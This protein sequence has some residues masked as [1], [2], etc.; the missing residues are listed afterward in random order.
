[1]RRCP[2]CR[3]YLDDELLSVQDIPGGVE[4]FITLTNPE[5]SI[6]GDDSSAAT[7]ERLMHKITN[8]RY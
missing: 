1:M 3:Q 6:Y 5:L 2:D 4:E 7:D 8:F